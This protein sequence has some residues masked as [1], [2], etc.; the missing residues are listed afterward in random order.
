V[1]RSL[2]FLGAPG[3]GKGTQA[4]LMVSECGYNH[5]STG[6][7]LRAE[8]AKLSPLGLKAKEI[9]KSGG[10]VGDDLVLELLKI[11]C[12]LE[13]HNY[14]FDGFPRNIA[15][16][17]ALEEVVLKGHESLAMYFFIDLNLLKERLVNRRA[18]PQ[19]GTIYNLVST[20]PKTENVC[21]KCG[22]KGLVHREDDKEEAVLNRLKVFESTITPVLDYYESRGILQRI[23]ASKRVDEIFSEVKKVLGI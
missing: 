11:N 17:K 4:K 5:L 21:D 3:S 9:M 2:I 23:D 14:V 8:V 19:C 22:H 18:C 13:K 6:D 16:A 1:G 15:Q 7:L 10:L 12:D 20:P